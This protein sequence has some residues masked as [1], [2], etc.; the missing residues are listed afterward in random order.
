MPTPCTRTTLTFQP[1]GNRDVC[2][3][4][5]GTTVTS[6]AGGLLLREV[7]A[8]CHFLDQFARCFTDYRDPDKVEHTLPELLK[9]RVFGLCLGYEDLNDHD[10]LRHDPSSPSS[11]ASATPTARAA[12]APPTAARPWPARAP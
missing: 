8:K 11:P 1:L 9:Q 7:E 5:D 6:D 2:A 3:R 10:T 4:F 12:P